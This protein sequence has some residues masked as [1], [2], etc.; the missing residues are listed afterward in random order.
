MYSS[1]PSLTSALDEGGWSTPHPG[2]FTPG[3]HSDPRWFPRPV[4][5]GRVRKNSP[6]PEFDPRTVQPVASLYM[7][8]ATYNMKNAYNNICNNKLQFSNKIFTKLKPS[9]IVEEIG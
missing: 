2:R 6:P 5:S 9:T 3:K 4:R 7:D 8:Y 1:T